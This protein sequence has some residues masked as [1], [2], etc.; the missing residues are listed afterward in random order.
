MSKVIAIA[1]LLLVACATV[2]PPE[3]VPSAVL[4]ADAGSAP[5][6]EVVPPSAVE[7]TPAPRPRRYYAAPMVAL[8]LV[9]LLSVI[10]VLGTIDE[11]SRESD[12][13][14]A[15]MS[16]LYL[17]GYLGGGPIIHNA[18]G[19]ERQRGPSFLRRLGYPLLV[20]VGGGLF[21]RLL[22]GD[23]SGQEFCGLGAAL[24]VVVGACV[25]V[26]AGAI[27]D[28]TKAYRN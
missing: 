17:A 25:G 12:R 6:A 24:G 2:R 14:F 13:A 16:A 22:E 11:R 23:C 4:A 1:C 9:I 5:Q 21:G 3:L 28:W 8:D 20:G 27:H 7:P 19:N 15:A 26:V 10:P 18:Y